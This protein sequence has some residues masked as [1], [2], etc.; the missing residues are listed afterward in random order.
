A[1]IRRMTRPHFRPGRARAQAV[2]AALGLIVAA[3]GST[4][5]SRIPS[6]SAPPS[7]VPS[8]V[9]PSAAATSSQSADE[10]Y[11]AIERQVVAI[12]GLKA[13]DVKRQTIDEAALR[14]LSLEDFDKDNPPD[15]VAA[16]GRLYHALGLLPPDG[17]IRALYLD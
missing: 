4:T 2:V 10:I 13:V 6:A 14:K 16:N 9:A 7:G 15:Y 17:D 12:R 1:T 11:N 8:A 3:C 5:P